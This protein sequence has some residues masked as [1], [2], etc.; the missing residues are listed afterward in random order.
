MNRP[1]PDEPL[2]VDQ[3]HGRA[4]GVVTR[5]LVGAIDYAAVAVVTGGTYLGWAVLQFLWNPVRFSWPVWPIGAWLILGFAYLVVYLWVAWATTGK[6]LGSVLM[7]TRV[8]SISGRRLGPVR[9]LLRAGFCAAFPI[10]LFVCAA[11]PGSR[12]LQDIVLLTKVA[13]HY[14]N[15]AV[16]VE[17][18]QD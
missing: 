9:A 13:Y 10:G 14:R 12:S 11:T 17:P 8:V 18:V 4:A 5:T 1:N 3:L 15:A 6:T 16:Q 2:K 7:G